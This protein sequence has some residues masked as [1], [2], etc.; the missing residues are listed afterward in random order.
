MLLH[1]LLWYFIDSNLHI[2]T[3]NNQLLNKHLLVSHI[4]LNKKKAKISFSWKLFRFIWQNFNIKSY[5]KQSII[6][7]CSHGYF[8]SDDGKNNLGLRIAMLNSQTYLISKET[9]KICGY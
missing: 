7:I 2:Y 4:V 8:H 6:Q 9:I 5:K 3:R 1:I